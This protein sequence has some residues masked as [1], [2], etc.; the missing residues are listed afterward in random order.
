MKALIQLISS[1]ICISVVFGWG[2]PVVDDNSMGRKSMC[3][4]AGESC[5]ATK[6]CCK[7]YVCAAFDELFGTDPKKPGYCVREKDLK[8]CDSHTDCDYRSA[9]RKLAHN[10]Q[11]YCVNDPSDLDVDE[12]KNLPA[13]PKVMKQKSKGGLGK[14]CSTSEECQ[15]H[16][17]DGSRLCCQKVH[18]Y[19]SGQRT[20]CDKVTLMST[21]I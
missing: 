1:A 20:L 14:S 6:E 11:M 2:M 17:K 16:S 9:C 4:Q 10:H 3:L 19:R 5:F 13:A 18:R 21:C 7:H 8:P 15:S 12:I